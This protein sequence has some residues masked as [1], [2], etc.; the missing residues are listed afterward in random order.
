MLNIRNPHRNVWTE[1][2]V[3]EPAPGFE[4]LSEIAIFQAD[5]K[6]LKLVLSALNLPADRPDEKSPLYR[7]TWPMWRGDVRTRRTATVR[8]RSRE[9]AINEVVVMLTKVGFGLN[10]IGEMN[11]EE[12]SDTVAKK[13]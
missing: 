13:S 4:Y 3:G 7:M 1:W 9:E 10:E 12:V 6:E 8:A 11:A 5:G 2:H